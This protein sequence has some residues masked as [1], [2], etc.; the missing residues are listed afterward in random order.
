MKNPIIKI[1]LCL[2]CSISV[3]VVLF[4]ISR[5]KTHKDNGFYRLFP[6]HPVTRAK[7][8]DLKF[9]SYYFA[10]SDNSRVYLSNVTAPLHL[11]SVN[12][13]N[14]DTTHIRLSV[15]D[16]SSTEFRQGTR[17]TV[18]SPYFYIADGIAPWLMRGTLGKWSAR[19]F[20]YDTAYFNRA[21]PIGPKSFVLKTMSSQTRQRI[22][23]K[24]TDISPYVKLVP[25]LLEKQIDG[26]FCTDGKLYYNKDLAQVVYVYDYRNQFIVMDTTLNLLF[27]GNTIDTTTRVKIKT[28]S[29]YSGKTKQLAAPPFLV[30]KTCA[31][32]GDYLFV[33]SNLMAK[34]ENVETFRN[35]VVIDVYHLKNNTYEFSFYIQPYKNYKLSH[36]YV[37]DNYLV[38]IH[39]QYLVVYNMHLDSFRKDRS[40]LAQNE[41]ERSSMLKHIL[42]R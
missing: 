8:I 41:R 22:L 3:V 29:L 30:N 23:A 17:V 38:A 27:R 40:V 14:L 13:P 2:V 34:N 21:V 4:A 35:T 15:E 5:E 12:L 10:G 31:T 1:S 11:L 39:G 32:S 9:N 37:A 28:A 20:M 6:P 42:S 33:H 25:G 16:Q 19:R 18:L 26:I 36:F 24:A 7:A